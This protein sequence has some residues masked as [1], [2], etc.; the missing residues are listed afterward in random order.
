VDKVAPK[1]KKPQKNE[2]APKNEKA[3]KNEKAPK[4]EKARHAPCCFFIPRP[5]AVRELSLN[6]VFTT[7]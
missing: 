5:F 7:R 1:T 2:K 6:P 4:N 3:L